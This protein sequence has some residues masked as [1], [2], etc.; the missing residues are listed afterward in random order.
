MAKSRNRVGY[1][2]NDT[3]LTPKY[4]FDALGA[5]FDLDVASSKSVYDEVGA[6]KCY[7]IDDDGLSQPWDGLV[8]CNPPYSNCTPWVDRLIE[9]N[10]GIA[11][12]PASKSKWGEKVFNQATAVLMLPYNFKF[13]GTNGEPKP[14][15][16]PVYLYAFGERAKSIL[17]NSEL[18]IVR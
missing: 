16:M 4:V 17:I 1:V 3:V 14:I 6:V 5:I 18:G 8:W 10:N 7:T 9:H 13:V 11:L 12:L 15:F 2:E